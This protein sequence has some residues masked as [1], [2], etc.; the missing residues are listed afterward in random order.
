MDVRLVV[1]GGKSRHREIRLPPT[2][3][4]IGR[5]PKCH[6]RPHSG[7]VSKLHCAIASWAGRVIVKDLGSANG[8]FVNQTRVTDRTNV[9]DGDLLEVGD[10]AFA[11]RIRKG[12]R[13]RVSSSSVIDEQE[14]GWLLDAPGDSLVLDP[15]SQTLIP[16]L[17]AREPA[18]SGEASL[19][20]K[21]ARGSGALS[22]GQYLRE[23][24]RR[25]KRSRGD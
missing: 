14:S 10:L 20:R 11:F 6:L 18:Q 5:H 25:R 17:K 19:R 21:K 3:F 8:T 2:V 7:L 16:S 9:R 13:G 23:Y 4:V 15:A 12:E 1:V 22:A 24:L